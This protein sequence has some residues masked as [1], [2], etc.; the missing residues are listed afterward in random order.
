MG[1]ALSP[2]RQL[3]QFT[4]TTFTFSRSLHAVLQTI[5]PSPTPPQAAQITHGLTDLQPPQHSRVALQY[6]P[7]AT[8]HCSSGLQPRFPAARAH[9]LV[10]LQYG[11]TTAFHAKLRRNFPIFHENS[12]HVLTTDLAVAGSVAHVVAGVRD[13][14]LKRPSS[15]GY[16]TRARTCTTS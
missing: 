13:R 5:S 11:P 15:P 9:S 16:P 10:T 14:V 8:L 12:V 1:V 3:S 4:H 6:G 2:P 7:T